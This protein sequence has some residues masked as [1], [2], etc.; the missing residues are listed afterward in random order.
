M[1]ALQKYSIR[2]IKQRLEENCFPFS[3]IT[4]LGSTEFHF[5]KPSF[6][7]GVVMH[8][9]SRIRPELMDAMLVKREN[10]F[11]EE[12]P[13]ADVFIR[14]MP[15]RII[16]RDSRFEYDLNREN[17]TCIYPYGDLKYGMDIWKRPLTADEKGPA[18]LKHQEFHDLIDLLIH[19]LMKKNRHA[20]IFDM[21]TYCYQR[22]GKRIWH[23]DP[24]PEINIGSKAV[25]R[26]IFGKAINTF[27]ESLSGQTIDGHPV[28]IVEN[29]VFMGG[30]L[31]RKL[32]KTWFKNVLVL[33]VEYKKIF[34]NEWT[35]EVFP[36]IL[37]E[38]LNNFNMAALDLTKSWT[39]EGHSPP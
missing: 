17:E 9:G 5:L 31:S 19:M 35:G 34:M 10:R 26:E 22:D 15:I 27:M 14:E 28:R 6:Y 12:D 33:A 37:K 36:E 32:S 20:L 29:E 16:A 13:Y 1:S 38:L 4:E 24:N 30:Y 2:E 18:I 39:S 25:N 23:E 3:G 8:T 21:H 11:R 7:A